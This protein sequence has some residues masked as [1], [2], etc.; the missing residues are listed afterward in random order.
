MLATLRDS[1]LTIRTNNH[2]RPILYVWDLT[3]EELKEF[4]YLISPPEGASESEVRDC[5]MDSGA[6]FFRYRGEVYDLGEFMHTTC[7]EFKGWAGYQSDS[8]FSGLLV[9]F[10]EDYEYVTVG[11]YFS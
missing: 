5:W 3:P 6:T 8:Y 9:K 4:D 1:K 2:K 7:P 11:T 10:D